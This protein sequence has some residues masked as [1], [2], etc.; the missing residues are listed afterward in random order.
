MKKNTFSPKP[1]RLPR[2][3]RSYVRQAFLHY[4]VPTLYFTQEQDG[5]LLAYPSARHAALRQ[6]R[7][8]ACY[9]MR[10]QIL[11]YHQKQR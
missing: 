7:L 8:N 9:G 5:T 3:H 4:R 6:M 10:K 1:P 11:T 2:Q